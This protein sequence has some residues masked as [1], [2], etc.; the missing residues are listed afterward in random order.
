M[1]NT[2]RALTEQIL[3]DYYLVSSSIED[4]VFSQVPYYID[5]PVF[6]AMV[7]ATLR[8]DGLVQRIIARYLENPGDKLFETGSF[9]LQDAVLK[10]KTPLL[11]FFWVRYDVFQKA[12][13]GIFFSEFNYDK[14]C[15]QREIIVSNWLQPDHNPNRNFAEDFTEGFQ[16]LW[17]A[18]NGAN[19]KPR[20]GILVDP[21]HYEEV[22]LA[23]LY[24]DLFQ[25]LDCEVMI[26]GGNNLRVENERVWA[27]DRE[28]NV[29][30]R[31][32][33]T[34][35][36]AEVPAMADLLR[37]FDQGKIL[38][39][40]DPRAIIGQTKSLFAYLW[41]LA[42]RNDPFLTPEEA[43]VIKRTIPYTSIYDPNKLESLRTNK[44]RY[45]IKA[46][47]GRYSE[48]VYIGT[49]CTEAEWEEVLQYVSASPK[50]HIV[51][52]FCPIKN[53]NLLRYN[54]AAYQEEEA[55]G[56]FGIYLINGRFAGTCVRWSRDYLTMDHTVWVT[57]VGVREHS[58]EIARLI[59]EGRDEQWRQIN[60]AALFQYGY[61]DSFTGTVESFSL[62][63]LVLSLPDFEEL[64]AATESCVTL[65]K[66]T[67]RLVQENYQLFSPVL[68]ISESLS[69]L[70]ARQISPELTFIGRFDWV[71]D[72]Q[73]HL[74]LL[75]F[76]SETPG[77]LLESIVLNSLIRKRL[78]VKG[79][80]PNAALGT[81]IKDTF[82]KIIADYSQVHAIRNIGIVSS[83]YHEDWYTT[84]TLFEQIKDLPF[85]FVI[86]EVSGLKMGDAGV[87]LYNTPL[88]ALYRYY[89]LDW[90]DS[91]PYYDGMVQALQYH[92]LSINSPA[93]LISQSK[94]FLALIW[95]L[96]EQGFYGPAEMDLIRRYLPQTALTPNKLTTNDFCIKPLFGREGQDIEYSF[97]CPE[98]CY[99]KN[100]N[101]FQARIDIQSVELDLHST[102][103]KYSQSVFPILGAYVVGD[104]FGGIFTRA[105]GRTTNK[106][107]IYLP[108]YI[109]P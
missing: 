34:E 8:L 51:Q 65:F 30:L 100:E 96:L 94:A 18:F 68:G 11:P 46:A 95:E 23:F 4:Q 82:S 69:E 85:N 44:N 41:E 1:L 77:G 107:V 49:M 103:G 105:G 22:H 45:V 93:T 104:K 36:L 37:L 98:N 70:I 35:F 57:A 99:Q 29:I 97:G 50:L 42:E 63:G 53:E 91:D 52:E 10:L 6:D 75:E 64:K 21:S 5:Q 43:E 89:P 86:G 109:A 54:G 12:G 25:A 17:Q 20:I 88:D 7:Q 73:G 40:N 76:N 56:N 13:G 39:I 61:T 28:I 59:T 79:H 72:A 108:T 62:Q 48:E 83:S 2:Q 90:L 92:T 71:F 74:K 58:L 67:T 66:Q 102:M 106:E 55:F 33:P 31:Q 24:M 78:N 87:S 80:D 101:V 9:P 19:Q 81:L 47:Y 3:F 26:V 60:E 84:M 38:I 27:F 14:P 15:A 32:Y 16:T